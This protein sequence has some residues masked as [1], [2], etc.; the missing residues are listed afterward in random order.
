MK[1]NI[2]IAITFLITTLM[3]CEKLPENG[4]LDGQWQLMEIQ[5]QEQP[6]KYTKDDAIYWRFQLD[7]LMIHS[8]KELLN[9]A[10]YDTSARFKYNGNQL[11]ITKT[12]IHFI[13]RDSLLTDPNTTA[14]VPLGIDGNAESFTIEELNRK[15]MVLTTEKKRLVFRKF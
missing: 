14:L 11:D 2:L 4:K 10:T 13:N 5:R 6:T 7:M 8:R 15:N 9:G 12:Y 3:G 1:A